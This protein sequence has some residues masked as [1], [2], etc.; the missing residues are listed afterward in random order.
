MPEQ[1]NLNS[2]V[3]I[4][5]NKMLTSSQQEVRGIH[6]LMYHTY[7]L[8]DVSY[9]DRTQGS[10]LSNL[11]AIRCSDMNIKQ[12]ASWKGLMMAVGKI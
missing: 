5:A 11:L 10:Y 1:K 9:I 4:T 12:L 6:R 8:Y 3:T 7:T 2:A